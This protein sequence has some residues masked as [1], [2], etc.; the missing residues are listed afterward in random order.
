MI[1]VTRY[2]FGDKDDLDKGRVLINYVNLE[3]GVT[4]IIFKKRA[5]KS[6]VHFCL[7]LL[8]S[9]GVMLSCFHHAAFS[10]EAA[11][12]T[13]VINP[14]DLTGSL[15]PSQIIILDNEEKKSESVCLTESGSNGVLGIIRISSR[16]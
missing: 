6:C 11:Q 4:M 12:V 1:K 3:E 7:L 2:R 14:T 8:L 16:D 5:V 10:A 13:I 15:L 9:I